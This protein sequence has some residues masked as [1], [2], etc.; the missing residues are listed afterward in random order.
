M[1]NYKKN[2]KNKKKLI[3]NQQNVQKLCV[4]FMSDRICNYTYY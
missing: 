4:K 3:F 2:K 1:S